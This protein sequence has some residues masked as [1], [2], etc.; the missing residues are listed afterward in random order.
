M[1]IL[2]TIASTNLFN[3]KV[4]KRNK[5]GLKG[6]SKGKTLGDEVSADLKI[7][8]KNLKKEYEFYI[9]IDMKY[10]LHSNGFEFKL[11]NEKKLENNFPFLNRKK[12]GF[13][14][15]IRN[16]NYFGLKYEKND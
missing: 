10:K 15:P 5:F 13:F 7:I 11:K 4:H 1:L 9:I 14:I 16:I 12:D 6:L 3:R 8:E 2:F